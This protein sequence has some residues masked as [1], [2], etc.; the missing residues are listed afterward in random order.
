MIQ[1]FLRCYNAHAHIAITIRFSTAALGFYGKLS[2]KEEGQKRWIHLLCQKSRRV[3]HK[4]SLKILIIVDLD[5][6][7]LGH[8]AISSIG[9]FN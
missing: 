9:G 7:M 1:F 2:C 8:A 4:W 5:G 3:E 6:F